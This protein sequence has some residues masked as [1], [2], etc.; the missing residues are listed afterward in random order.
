MQR[1]RRFV[2]SRWRATLRARHA[3]GV[4]RCARFLRRRA[5]AALLINSRRSIRRKLLLKKV[6]FVRKRMHMSMILQCLASNAAHVLSARCR[7]A[8]VR[9]HRSQ[10][11]RSTRYSRFLDAPD[12]DEQVLHRA[13]M[14]L[15]LYANSAPRRRRDY[16]ES[17]EKA[18]C[19]LRVHSHVNRTDLQVRCFVAT[20]T[21]MALCDW[22]AFIAIRRADRL[23]CVLSGVCISLC[24]QLQIF[25]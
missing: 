21:R 11:V 9:L 23:A 20:K 18:V 13:L 14:S 2:L 22:S 8:A 5:F 10:A 16:R 12:A 19:W 25:T 1:L 7:L 17:S 15:A 6:A 4:I 3:R 24:S